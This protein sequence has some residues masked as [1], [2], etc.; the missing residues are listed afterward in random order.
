[1]F[2]QTVL[3]HRAPVALRSRM[4]D[5]VIT[6]A[7]V[8]D[9]G[10][11]QFDEVID[12]QSSPGDI[13]IRNR[14]HVGDR[15]IVASHD[16]RWNFSRDRSEDA[17]RPPVRNEN[18]AFHLKLQKRVDFCLLKSGIGASRN[19]HRAEPV[20]ANLDLNAFEDLGKNRIVQIE[21]E[22]SDGVASTNREASG[23]GVSAVTQFGSG[24]HD[25]LSTHV[26]D[27][28]RAGKRK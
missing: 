22:H 21:N 19:Q 18:E 12:R 17:C 3:R 4:R 14:V 2:R 27:L 9:S 1:V 20:F 11:P 6:T 16:D 15:D 13:V 8:D 24:V 26:T 7:Q 25:S 5:R 23:R 28:C 10:M